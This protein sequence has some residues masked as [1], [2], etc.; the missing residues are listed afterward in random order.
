MFKKSYPPTYNMQSIDF[1]H[2]SSLCKS[3]IISYI[4]D[5]NMSIDVINVNG[6][7]KKENYM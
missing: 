1:T 4:M 6:G 2:V 7:N 3:R 5:V